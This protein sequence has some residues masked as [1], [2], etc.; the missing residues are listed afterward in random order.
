MYPGALGRRNLE[1]ATPDEADR[2]IVH[3]II[4]DELCLAVFSDEARAAYVRI[5]DKLAGQGC[6]SVAM[7]CTEIP[8]LVKQDVCNLPVFDTTLIHAKYAVDFALS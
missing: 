7:V 4:F 2:A 8:L 5:I 6:D 3:D 1:W